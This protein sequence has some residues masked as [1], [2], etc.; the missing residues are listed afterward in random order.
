MGGIDRRP[1]D[2]AGPGVPPGR[3]AAC[4][5]G[6]FSTSSVS[7]AGGAAGTA[8]VDLAPF[9]RGEAPEPERP[10]VMLEFVTETRANR[11]YYDKRWRG[12]RGPRHKYT[13][14][15]DMTGALPWQ[16]FDLE[17]D[18]FELRNLLAEP[19]HE[20][21]AAAMHRAL[22]GLLDAA[23]DDFALAPAFGSP[24]RHAVPERVS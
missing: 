15:G 17:A 19:G 6:S 5:C 4:R 21:V 18:P 23:A 7:R 11:S 22:I 8:R 1:A 9:I 10:G 20:P 24:A 14:L 3:E 16:L 12:I 13:V 2:R